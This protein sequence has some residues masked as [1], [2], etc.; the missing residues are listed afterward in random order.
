[1]SLHLKLLQ[2]F[3]LWIVRKTFYLCCSQGN[4]Q[5]KA[6]EILSHT[7]TS[8]RLSRSIGSHI[9]CHQPS[10]TDHMYLQINSYTCIWIR[11]ENITKSKERT[12][13]FSFYAFNLSLVLISIMHNKVVHMKVTCNKLLHIIYISKFKLISVIPVPVIVEM[14]VKCWHPFLSNVQLCQ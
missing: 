3:H 2:L 11:T 7:W 8:P 5:W 10:N 9:H 4:V 1:M 14:L 12:F 13:G 6:P